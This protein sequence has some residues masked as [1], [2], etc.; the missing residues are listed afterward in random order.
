MFSRSLAV[1][2][3]AGVA[4]SVMSTPSAQT[5]PSR[6]SVR[7]YPDDPLRRDIDMRSDCRAS[8]TRPLQE[9]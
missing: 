4:A 2:L 1:F 7:F 3:L 5:L 8:G 9:L 6:G